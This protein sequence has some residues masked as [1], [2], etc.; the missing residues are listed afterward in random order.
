MFV[1]KI[2]IGAVAAFLLLAGAGPAA[3]Q[4]PERGPDRQHLVYGAGTPQELQVYKIFGRQP[5]PT[6]LI[7][8]GIQGDEAGGFMSADLY[9]DLALKK[10]NLIVVPRAN[11]KSIIQYHRGPDGDM[12]RKFRGDLDR[13]PERPI[14]EA[15]KAL[16]AESDLV[17]NLHDGSGYYRHIWESDLANPNRYGQCIIAD[18]DVYTHKPSGRIIPLKDYA[19]DVVER[20]NRQIDDPQQKFRFSNHNTEAPDSRHKEQKGSVSYYALTEL[21]I[22]AFGVETSK[23]LPSLELK[24]YQHNLAVNAFL[25]VFGLE[26][27]QPRIRLEAPYLAYLLIAVNNGT[28]LAVADGQTLMV[29]PGAAVEVLDVVSNFDRGLSAD[30]K[31]LGGFN[32]LGVPLRIEQPTSIE[33]QKD[34]RRIGRISLALLPAGQED[35][36]PRLTGENRLRLPR[37]EA[38]AAAGPEAA[39][40]LAVLDSPRNEIRQAIELTPG[41]RPPAG[42]PP[43]PARVTGFLI[44]VDGWPV[45]LAPGQKLEVMSGSLIKMVDL[46]SDGP[47]PEKT[48][49]NLKGFMPKSKLYKNDGEDR[50]F[51]ADTGRDLMPAFSVGQR[52][53]DYEINA[54]VGPEVRASC[55]IRLTPPKL[56]SATIEI[57]G[58]RQTLTPGGRFGIPPGAEVTVLAVELA[59]GRELGNPRFTL[60]GKPFP[61]ELPQTLKMPGF[62]VNLAVF[63]GEVLA[64]KVLWALKP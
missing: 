52:G 33:V 57:D 5:G 41:P 48:V 51:T 1:K 3:A 44:E 9:V 50:G 20:I 23:Q 21:G 10:G 63:N 8:G 43:A 64:G 54:E 61:A 11:F 53:R 58:R 15:L 12:N 26:L 6:V 62:G 4:G 18:A 13:D 59:D 31:G 34:Q 46:K 37:A 49:M 19:E 16:M 25:E 38:V 39:G 35:Q 29:A 40:R 45:E 42:A 27:E 2:Y 32:D 30:V 55:S 60:G 28:P 24:I 36:S 56:V 17:L 7:I 14:V 22:P 47:L